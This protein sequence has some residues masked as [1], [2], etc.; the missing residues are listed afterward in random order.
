MSWKEARDNMVPMEPFDPKQKTLKEQLDE[1]P[2]FGKAV[3]HL[4]G[5]VLVLAVLFCAGFLGIEAW[6]ALMWAAHR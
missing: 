5:G 4:L 6:S 3:I 1:L 2:W